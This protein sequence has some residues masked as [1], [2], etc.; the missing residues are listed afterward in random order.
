MAFLA[1]QAKSRFLKI[2][3]GNWD[4][5]AIK[6]SEILETTRISFTLT[7]FEKW[8]DWHLA[9]NSSNMVS[10]IPNRNPVDIGDK[11]IQ[12]YADIQNEE[13]SKIART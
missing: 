10:I 7:G 3:H 13:K 12:K 11:E 2:S 5:E 4:S 6:R 8:E 9:S 1:I